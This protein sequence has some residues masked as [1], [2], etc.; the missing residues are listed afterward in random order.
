MRGEA[1]GGE[2]CKLRCR[3][4]AL[5]ALE[6]AGG[7]REIQRRNQGRCKTH[8]T[9]APRKDEDRTAQLMAVPGGVQ[10]GDERRGCDEG[11][12]R[13]PGGAFMKNARLG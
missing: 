1:R 3:P 4:A 7:Q 8:T 12:G 6:K 11:K 13:R 10:E 9:E 2:G 5:F